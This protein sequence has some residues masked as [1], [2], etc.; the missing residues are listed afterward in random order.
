MKTKR[1][2][3]DDWEDLIGTTF[4]ILWYPGW[5]EPE[6]REVELDHIHLTWDEFGTPMYYLLDDGFG[7]TGHLY[8]E[9]VEVRKS[10]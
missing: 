2:G 10:A 9:I 5:E 1:Q 3:P 8:S 4:E 6:W 7:G